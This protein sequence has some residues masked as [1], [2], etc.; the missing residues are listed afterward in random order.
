MSYANLPADVRIAAESVLTRRQLTVFQLWSNGMGTARI[1]TMLDISE[2]VARRHK[3]RAVQKI[4]LHLE[5][6]VA[7]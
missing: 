6:E 3:D 4:K 7:A 1:A 2:P 5:K